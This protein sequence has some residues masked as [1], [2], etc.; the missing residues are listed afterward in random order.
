[1]LCLGLPSLPMRICVCV[2][3]CI[4]VCVGGRGAHILLIIDLLCGCHRCVS[5]Y[6]LLYLYGEIYYPVMTAAVVVGCHGDCANF[7]SLPQLMNESYLI[8]VR[9]PLIFAVF[10]G[11]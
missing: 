3:V 7:I 2:C 6:C 4:C 1:M 11:D 8:C 9:H 10:N 5:T